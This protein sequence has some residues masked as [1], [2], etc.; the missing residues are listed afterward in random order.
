MG[1]LLHLLEQHLY[2]V[3]R[4]V[5]CEALSGQGTPGDPTQEARVRHEARD[6]R[7]EVPRQLDVRGEGVRRE[8][9]R[10]HHS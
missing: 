1:T 7:H 8:E 9:P 2:V 4:H 10:V 3:H 6:P 5:V